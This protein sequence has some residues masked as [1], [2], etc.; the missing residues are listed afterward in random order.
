M[1]SPSPS[2]S[3]P[4]GTPASL[5][6]FEAE[7]AAVR[8]AA[9]RVCRAAGGGL[10]DP[11]TTAAA[12]EGWEELPVRLRAAVRAFRRNSGECGVTLVTGLPVD[13]AL[14][15]PTPTADGSVRREA[16][17][18]AATLLM[19]AAGGLGDPAAY[20]PEKSGALVQDVVPVPGKEDFEG[21]AGSTL[22][23]FHVE[24]AFHVHRP[25][26]VMLL[27]LRADH[28]GAAGLRTG[29]I[30]QALPVLSERTRE[31]LFRPEFSTQPPPSFGTAA[32][33]TPPRPVLTG[34]PEDPDLRVDFSATTAVTPEARRAL[35]ELEAAVDAA[36]HTVRLTPGDLAIVDNRVTTHG[37]TAFRPRYDGGDRWLLRTFAVADLR[38]S[39]DYRPGDG[40]VLSH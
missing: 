24:N 14:L 38:R 18:P 22:L 26:F 12:R 11:E 23:S 19:T 27:C 6:L 3:L 1:T 8:R 40:H 32:G 13:E 29:S 7:T 34:D 5:A 31:A 39:R 30:R 4:V 36:S 21:N 10:D 15:P 20:A 17:V 16:T 37:R 9:E 35:V 2:L 33:T 25:D 28:D